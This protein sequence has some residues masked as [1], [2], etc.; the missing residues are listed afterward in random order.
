MSGTRSSTFGA[1]AARPN[2]RR[3]DL[4]APRPAPE[5]AAVRVA[6]AAS[7]PVA[8]APPPSSERRAESADRQPEHGPP[9]V[10]R[11]QRL[12]AD[13]N[14]EASST[15]PLVNSAENVD[16]SWVSGREP[17]DSRC[18]GVERTAHLVGSR[19][20]ERDY[21]A[22]AASAY[23]SM[24]AGSAS[25][26]LRARCWLD[27]GPAPRPNA[28]M[29]QLGEDVCAAL[30][31]SQYALMAADEHR[32]VGLLDRLGPAPRL[33][34]S[35]RTRPAKEFAFLGPQV[36]HPCARARVCGPVLFY[37]W[38]TPWSSIIVL[39]LQAS[40]TGSPPGRPTRGPSQAPTSPG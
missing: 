25:R 32:W 36:L 7:V 40:Y 30:H 29:R 34:R 23:W 27:R 3:P 33:V 37:V 16:V 19:R 26:R 12:N 4:A 2:R 38:L 9:G 28:S 1:T 14:A 5:A 20:R 24:I 39:V 31:P 8:T 13:L 15:E 10:G 21:A 18:G 35:G 6:N 17:L 22:G 11:R